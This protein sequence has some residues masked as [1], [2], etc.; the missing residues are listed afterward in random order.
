YNELWGV[1]M[2]LKYKCLILD[3]DDTGVKSTPDIHYPSFVEALRDLRPNDQP[4]TFEDFVRFCFDPGFSSLCKDVLKFTEEEQKHQQVV[5]KR[6]TES[7]VPD[8]YELFV[9]IV[10]E[11]KRRDRNVTVVYQSERNQIERDYAIHRGFVPDAIYREELPE[12]Q[13]KSYPY[14]KEEI[15]IRF[16]HQET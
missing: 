13:R 12:H 11:L 14:P 1:T 6:Y 2:T 15:S 7:I 9:E 4:I 3:H 10:Q 5:W 8:F 16:N